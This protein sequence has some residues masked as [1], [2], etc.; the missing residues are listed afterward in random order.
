MFTN[1]ET[2]AYSVRAPVSYVKSMG[3]FFMSKQ[4]RIDELMQLASE[5]G[6]ALPYP[7]EVIIGL[8]DLGLYVDLTTG[9]TGSSDERFSLTAIGEA[10]VAAMGGSD[11]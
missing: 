8:E 6:F 9:L 5:E 4:R 7:P 3:D 1:P 10:T 2:G 11:E